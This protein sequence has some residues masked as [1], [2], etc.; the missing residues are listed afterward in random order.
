MPTDTTDAVRFLLSGLQV[1]SSAHVARLEHRLWVSD[2]VSD[3][4]KGAAMALNVND[5]G[6]PPRNRT[7]NPQIKSLL[8]CQ[9]S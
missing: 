7:E 9:L 1:R 2:R 3:W 4:R 6:E 5:F 8:L